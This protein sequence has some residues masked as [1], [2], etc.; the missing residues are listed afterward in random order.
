MSV[1]SQNERQKRRYFAHCRGARGLSESSIRT[2]ERSLALWDE[3]TDFACYK[4]FSQRRASQFKEYLQNR[5]V[6]AARLSLTTIANHLRQVRQFFEWLSGQ[7]GYKSRIT[8]DSISFL[9]LNRKEQQMVRNRGP[10]DYP[11]I[12]YVIRL[13]DSI[14]LDTEIGQ[15]DRALISFLLLTGMRDQAVVSLPIG[16]YDPESLMVDQDPSRGVKTKFSKRIVTRLMVFDRLLLREIQTWYDHLA[17]QRLFGAGDPLFPRTK[18]I[19]DANALSFV[20]A[21]VEPVFWQTAGPVRE[22]LRQRSSSAGL[23]YYK[24]HSF[25]HACAQ[26]G[27]RACNNPEQLKALSQNLGHEDVATT[28]TSY[29]TLDPYRVRDVVGSISFELSHPQQTM[30]A[31]EPAWLAELLREG[32]SDE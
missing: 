16:C 17:G 15:R 29:G 8:A 25:R 4:S 7:A 31:S 18:V 19:Q 13:V 30:T 10:V 22:I 12:P 20:T 28:L 23:K 9:S 2:A 6:T 27:I 3:A 21:G 26:H 1:R 5:S 14:S 32:E 24:P 11:S